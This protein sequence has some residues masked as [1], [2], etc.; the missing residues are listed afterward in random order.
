MTD[1]FV[2]EFKQKFM[3]FAAG[4]IKKL[5][6]DQADLKKKINLIFDAR[7]VTKAL[8]HAV[9]TG[10]WVTTNLGGCNRTGISQVLNRETNYLSVISHLRKISTPYFKSTRYVNGRLLHNTHYGMYCPAE[11]PEGA[12]IGVVK[13]LAFLAVVSRKCTHEEYENLMRY[14]DELAPT[15]NHW[16]ME[17]EWVKD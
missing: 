6:S 5:A 13:H 11:S 3:R 16:K 14:V 4:Y 12:K 7:I 9:S 1:L 15:G 10:N 2:V 8:L 17:S